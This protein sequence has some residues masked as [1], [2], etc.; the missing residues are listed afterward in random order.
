MDHFPGIGEASG[1]MPRVEK[2]NYIHTKSLETDSE[3][4]GTSVLMGAQL[5][6]TLIPSKFV[7]CHI[8]FPFR[9]SYTILACILY[10]L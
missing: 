4:E 9:S 7:A 2:T 5:I 6:Q 3:G 10:L 1:S 8:T